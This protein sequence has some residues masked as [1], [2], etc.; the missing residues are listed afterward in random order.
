MVHLKKI[1][2][3]KL[4]YLL[5]FLIFYSFSI[6]LV[7]KEIEIR[8]NSNKIL[9]LL[10][11]LKKHSLFQYKVLIDVV[12]YDRPGKK[13]RFTIVY[14]LLNPFFN[15]RILI[16]TQIKQLACLDSVVSIFSNANWIEREIWDMFGI[17]FQSHP[18]L[19]RILTDY[20]FR[21]HP[22]RKDFPLSGITES[23]FSEFTSSIAH[24][25]VELV[26]EYRSFN[27]Y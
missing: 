27:L 13:N 23:Y 3:Y 7:H 9:F 6:W 18:D 15:S 1:F 11:I 19:R 5:K 25:P 8:F 10:N 17:F 24:K 21:G 22:L 12:V 4:N 16:R 14:V 2:S 20:G 26:Q